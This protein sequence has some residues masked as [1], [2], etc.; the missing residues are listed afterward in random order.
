MG[1]TMYSVSCGLCCKNTI[2]RQ[3]VVLSERA[4]DTVRIHCYKRLLA[5]NRNRG[6]NE[7]CHVKWEKTA[8][9]SIMLPDHIP[10]HSGKIKKKGKRNENRHY[11]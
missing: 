3:Q 1:I 2:Q 7:I 6:L 10:G 9:E 11:F 8:V 4:P 5:V